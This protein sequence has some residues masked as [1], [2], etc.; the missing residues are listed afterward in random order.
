LY[1][2]QTLLNLKEN[3]I[4]ISCF[5]SNPEEFHCSTINLMIN[6]ELLLLSTKKGSDKINLAFERDS[7]V[8]KNGIIKYILSSPINFNQDCISYTL[9]LL[10]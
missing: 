8:L 5:N 1:V 2:N 9:M 3:E 7:E 4:C 10:R 6:A